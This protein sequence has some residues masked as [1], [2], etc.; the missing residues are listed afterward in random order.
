[1]TSTPNQTQTNP[2]KIPVNAYPSADNILFLF[3]VE[4]LRDNSYVSLIEIL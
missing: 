3:D 4:S 2:T 1:M